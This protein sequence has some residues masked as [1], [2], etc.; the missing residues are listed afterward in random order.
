MNPGLTLGQYQKQII[1]LCLILLQAHHCRAF[2]QLVTEKKNHTT[3]SFS[4][5]R[6]SSVC[7]HMLLAPSL[8]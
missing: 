1:P 3:L 7:L 4:S 6:L 2:L 5:N 8:Y